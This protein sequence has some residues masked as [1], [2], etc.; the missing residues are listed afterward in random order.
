MERQAPD[1]SP[2]HEYLAGEVFA[3]SGASFAH[4]R[5]T[6]NIV[7]ALV[8]ALTGRDC[9]AM[10]CP[11]TCAFISQR[12]RCIPTR[13]WS[14]FAANLFSRTKVRR[15]RSPTQSR[16]SRCCHPRPDP[17]YRGEKFAHYRRLR[18]FGTTSWSARTRHMRT[19]R[20]LGTPG[21]CPL[22]PPCRGRNAR[23]QCDPRLSRRITDAWSGVS[24]DGYLICPLN[25]RVLPA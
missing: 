10:C 15:T 24:Q 22:A 16:C 2:R 8:N 14:W 20:T 7:H 13:M 4:N 17:I 19:Y 6:A 1:G 3:M 9:D 5:I 12:P 18:R 23:R 25:K 21:Q 11:A